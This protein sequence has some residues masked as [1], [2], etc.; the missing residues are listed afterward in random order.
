MGEVTNPRR[1]NALLPDRYPQLELFLC[2]VV[3]AVLKSDIESMAHPVFA[4]STSPNMK[5]VRYCN[6]D[7]YL[8]VSPSAFGRATIHDRDVLIY[9]ISQAMHALNN[10][11]KVSK[12]MRFRASDILVATN[13][14]R[15]GRGYELLKNSFRRLQGTQ[16]ETN[17]RRD[18]EEQFKVFGLLE[19]AHVIRETSTGRMIEVEVILSDWIFD[20]IEDRH[21]LTLDRT[22]FRLRRPLERRLYEIARK[23]CGSQKS[24]QIGLEKL[25]ERCGSESSLREFRRLVKRILADDARLDY[26]P[27]YKYALEG[28]K[29]VVRNADWV[30][31][32]PD[33][34]APMEA[35]PL[36]PDVLAEARRAAPGWD[37]Y[38]LESEWRAWVQRKKIAVKHPD[39]HFVSFC[40]ARGPCLH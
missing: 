21:V 1:G 25:R 37:I 38:V 40:R 35:A 24:W 36:G 10:R 12:R 13:R 30:E 4:L 23:F 9:C 11:E 6:G 15:S 33:T 22:Y 39:R 18:G 8:Q 34:V 27:Q 2:D 3:D 7:N 26:M 19:S 20:A 5:P 31:P 32:S 16:I 14:Q 17:I 29:L 28:D